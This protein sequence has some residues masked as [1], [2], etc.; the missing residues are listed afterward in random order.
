MRELEQRADAAISLVGHRGAVVVVEPD[1]L[2]LGAHAPLLRRLLPG[3]HVVDQLFDRPD[4]SLEIERRA[5]APAH[6]RAPAS[7]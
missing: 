3:S 7:A 2:V 6:A 1:L 5:A 4:G